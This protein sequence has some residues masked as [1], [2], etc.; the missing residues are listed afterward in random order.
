MLSFTCIWE[1]SQYSGQALGW[2]IWGS[3]F[4]RGKGILYSAKCPGWLWAHPASFAVGTFFGVQQPGYEADPLP[5]FNAEV[6]N[7]CSLPHLSLHAFA[8]Y[9]VT[10]LTVIPTRGMLLTGVHIFSQTIQAYFVQ[11]HFFNPSPME[12]DRCQTIKCSVLSDSTY[13]DLSF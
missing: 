3:N 10:Y 6:K 2:K 13:T 4:D 1:V 11:Q 9:A 7:E 5:P 12:L 8:A